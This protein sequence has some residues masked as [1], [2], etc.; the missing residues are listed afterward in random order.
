M[1]LGTFSL[2]LAVKDITASV[3]FYQALGFRQIGG[4][5]D[6]NWVILESGGTVIGLFQGM[7]EKNMMTF[8]PGWSAPGVSAEEFDDIRKIQAMLQEVGITP[9]RPAAPDADGPDHLLIT[10]PDGN[11]IM[12]D[13]HVPKPT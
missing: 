2:S 6:Q 8:N 13:Q 4:D 9:I 11:T 10:D 7:F 5:M 3:A 1:Q 12:L